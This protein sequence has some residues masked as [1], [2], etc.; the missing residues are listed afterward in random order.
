MNLQTYLK[1]L[2]GSGECNVFLTIILTNGGKAKTYYPSCRIY[3]GTPQDI[4][5]CMVYT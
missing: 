1:I 5:V 3:F 2:A 4:P